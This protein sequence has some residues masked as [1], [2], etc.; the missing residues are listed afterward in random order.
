MNEGKV[1]VASSCNAAVASCQKV[2]VIALEGVKSVGLQ[3]GGPKRPRLE[4]R[5]VNE[6][7]VSVGSTDPAAI[8]PGKVLPVGSL[9]GDLGS[10]NFEGPG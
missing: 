2:A 6:S 10:D 3:D 9:E 8:A 7:R 5:S 1:R 4:I